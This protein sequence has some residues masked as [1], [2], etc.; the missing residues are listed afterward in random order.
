MLY[1]CY[2]AP[3]KIEKKPRKA[4]PQI[5]SVFQQKAALFI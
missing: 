4:K 1:I 2:K 5:S 3:S